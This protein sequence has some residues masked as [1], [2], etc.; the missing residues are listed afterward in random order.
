MVGRPAALLAAIASRQPPS[1]LESRS[2]KWDASRVPLPSK[3]KV[4]SME[5]GPE[6]RCEMP[7]SICAR[8]FVWTCG[9]SS[10]ARA[11]ESLGEL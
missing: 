4:P 7:R 6:L 3:V 5:I 2:A 8:R 9:R 11:C 10:D 1:V